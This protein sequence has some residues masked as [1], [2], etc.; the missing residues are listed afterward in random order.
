MPT[1]ILLMYV[2]MDGMMGVTL[3]AAR[4]L[5]FSASSIWFMLFW[6]VL[7]DRRMEKVE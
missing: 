7:S 6:L 5:R 1:P 2:R 4:L 3:N